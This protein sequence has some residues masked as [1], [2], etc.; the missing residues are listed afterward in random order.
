MFFIFYFLT[1]LIII[2]FIG[3]GEQ[4]RIL[5]NPLLHVIYD[6]FVGLDQFFLQ[7]LQVGDGFLKNGEKEKGERTNERST[8]STEIDCD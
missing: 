5:L 7:G 8:E 3:H 1:I 6:S 4:G 2:H